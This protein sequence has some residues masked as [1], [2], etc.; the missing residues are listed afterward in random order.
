VEVNNISYIVASFYPKE[1]VGIKNDLHFPAC[2]AVKDKN[3]N[4][5]DCATLLIAHIPPKLVFILNDLAQQ[6]LKTE[7]SIN[8]LSR[9]VINFETE[10][11]ELLEAYHLV[12]KPYLE[13]SFERPK[14]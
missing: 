11:D 13:C 1:L 14:Q 12:I 7:D 8:D 2:K 5:C 4:F 3:P 10:H 6:I 9:K